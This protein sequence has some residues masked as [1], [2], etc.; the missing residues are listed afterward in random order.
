[1]SNITKTLK[2]T[3][4]FVKNFNSRIKLKNDNF[5]IISNNC[6]GGQVYK[7]L[8]KPYN[9]PFVGLFIYG[10]CYIKLLENLDYYLHTPLTFTDTSQYKETPS[11]PVGLLH[12]IEIHF[13]HYTDENEAYE[14]W[15]RRLARFNWNNIFIKL[16]DRD[17]TSEEHVQRFDALTYPKVFFSSKNTPGI[18]SLVWFREFEN[19]STV[20][21]EMLVYKKYF[22]AVNWLNTGK[23][24]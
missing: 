8:G 2:S 17:L 6:W 1:M 21:N 10:P 4:L 15:N 18:N 12:D 20:D 24:S 14:K 22:N 16:S 7:N 13:M 3:R 9:T 19:S 5:S 23:I 11:Y